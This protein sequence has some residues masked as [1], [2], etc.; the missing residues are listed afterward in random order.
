M[1]AELFVLLIFSFSKI[2]KKYNTE[3][4]SFVAQNDK[5]RYNNMVD[6]TIKKQRQHTIIK[7]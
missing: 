6:F 5:K 3:L 1:W 7:I 4:S 2:Q